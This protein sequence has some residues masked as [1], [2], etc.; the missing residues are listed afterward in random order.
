MAASVISMERPR[1]ASVAWSSRSARNGS[2]TGASPAQVRYASIE[3]ATSVRP[4]TPATG[5]SLRRPKRR[6]VSGSAHSASSSA[7][8]P[9]RTTAT[10]LAPWRSDFSIR[11]TSA[12]TSPPRRGASR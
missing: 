6:L 5:P 8:T 2:S 4:S 10:A 1:L 3:R 11:S 12:A 9:E 7:G